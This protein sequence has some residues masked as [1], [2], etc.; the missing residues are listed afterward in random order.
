MRGLSKESR[1]LHPDFRDILCVFLEEGVEFLVVGGYAV[2]AHGLPGATKDIGLWV[3]C[4]PANASRV[5]TAL[6]RFGAAVSETAK[7]DFL[8][9]HH[10][11]NR[12]TSPQ[13]RHHY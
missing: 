12:H 10:V 9:G 3:G 7:K 13:D 1:L 8:R 11:S 6:K 5:L 2:A 4:S